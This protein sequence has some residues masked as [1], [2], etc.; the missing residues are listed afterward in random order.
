MEGGWKDIP[1]YLLL[2]DAC[3]AAVR[4][5][6]IISC[7]TKTGK[8]LTTQNRLNHSK[9]LLTNTTYTVKRS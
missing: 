1:P 9:Y 8:L 3:C 7:I 2:L 5:S 4:S 6:R